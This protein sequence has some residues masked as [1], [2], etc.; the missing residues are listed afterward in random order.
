MLCVDSVEARSILQSLVD[1]R[2]LERRGPRGGSEYPIAP[3]LGVPARIRHTD[4][5][6]DDLLVRFAR[7]GPLTNACVRER[8]GL[9]RQAA[10]IA[11]QRLIAAGR[12]GGWC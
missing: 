3:D 8:T 2:V 6:L 5:E 1:E 9:D 10:L 4:D 12:L 11:L 7:Q